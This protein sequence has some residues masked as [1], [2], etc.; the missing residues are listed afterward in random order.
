MMR[1]AQ[2]KSVTRVIAPGV[3]FVAYVGGIEQVTDPDATDGTCD[4]IPAHHTK[5][6]CRLTW[7]GRRHTLVLLTY[8]H[9]REWFRIFF[10]NRR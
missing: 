2:N 3:T 10:L 6:E 1:S 9:E 7:T 8:A 4:G 5:L